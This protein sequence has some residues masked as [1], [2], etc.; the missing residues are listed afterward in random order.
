VPVHALIVS[1]LLLGG[2]PVRFDSALRP[3]FTV[4]QIQ[5]TSEATRVGLTKWAATPHGRKLIEFFQATG[6][7]I[8][9]IEDDTERGIG[10]APEPGIATLVAASTHPSGR[11]RFEIILNPTYYRLPKDMRPLAGQLGSPADA[12]AI[13]WAGE[14]LH[15]YF[16]A[17]GISLPHHARADFQDEWQAVAAELGMGTVPHDDD[18]E[19]AHSV[20]VRYVGYGR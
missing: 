12:M 16:Y 4:E 10:R 5:N 3:Q 11:K 20:I 19:F 9:V 6:C 17:H 1:A 2:R 18:D 13:A 8:T 15:I 7:E 14:M